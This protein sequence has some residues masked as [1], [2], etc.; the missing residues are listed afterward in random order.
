L[1]DFALRAGQSFAELHPAG[2]PFVV[3]PPTVIGPADDRPESGIARSFFVACLNGVRVSSR[4]AFLISHDGIALLDFQGDELV[5]LDDWLELDPAVFHSSGNDV[6]TIESDEYA[7][8]ELDEAFVSLVGPHNRSFGDWLGEYLPKYVLAVTAGFLP[9]VPVLVDAGMPTANR[10][11]LEL[12]LPH[13]VP[14]VELPAST[15][16]VVRRAW[17]AP[18]LRYAPLLEKIN[19]KFTGFDYQCFPPARFAPVLAEMARRVDEMLPPETIAHPRV[20][21]A[22]RDTLR[23]SLTNRSVVEAI[24]ESHGFFIVYPEEH[25]F[26]TQVALVRNARFLIGPEGSAMYLTFFARREMKLCILSHPFILGLLEYTGLFREAGVDVTIFTGPPVR[27]NNEPGYP[28]FGLP[29]YADY[30]IDEAAFARFMN[31]W[32]T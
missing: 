12:L 8:L 17:C 18:A 3:R 26:V 27:L 22:R 1:R 15:A 25:D 16:A 5:R 4:S 9:A 11:A 19:D 28:N 7:A 24:A 2:Q 21:F 13:G 30:E 31:E 20:Y 23:R 32:L 10:Q 29:Q 14:I 6:W